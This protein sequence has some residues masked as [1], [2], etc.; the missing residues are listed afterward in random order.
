[1]PSPLP[2][3]LSLCAAALILAGSLALSSSSFAAT[4]STPDPSDPYESD[5]TRTYGI[6]SDFRVVGWDTESQPGQLLLNLEWD[7]AANAGIRGVVF[8]DTNRDG[9]ADYALNIEYS[10]FDGGSRHPNLDGSGGKVRYKLEQVTKSTESCQSF[11]DGYDPDDKPWTHPEVP[12]TLRT[13][14]TKTL[15]TIPIPIGDIGT[16]RSFVWAA[17]SESE[18]GFH[19]PYDFVPDGANGGEDP[20]EGGPADPQKNYGETNVFYCSPSDGEDSSS[21]WRVRM[22]QGVLFTLVA[23]PPPEVTIDQSPASGRPGD[24][25]TFTAQVKDG[26]QI[27]S[28]AWDLDGDDQFDDG[29]TKTVSKHFP[30]GGR[31]FVRVEV[32]DATQQS[33]IGERTVDIIDAKP[34]VTLEQSPA[35]AR[36]KREVQLTAKATDDGTITGYAWDLDNDGEFDDA[37]GATTSRTFDR[38]GTFTVGVRVSDDGGNAPEVKR[39]VVV[40]ERAPTLRLVASNPSPKAREKTTISAEIVDDGPVDEAD[41]TWGFDADNKGDDDDPY[42]KHRG[43]SWTVGF[44]IP[45]RYTVKAQFTDDT[46]KTVRE[47]IVIDVPN[48]PP[49][50]R[51]IRVRVKKTPD[52]PFNRDLLVKDKPLYLE[53]LLFDDSLQR[54]RVDWDI[55]NDGAYDDATGERVEHTFATPGEKTVGV[56]ITDDG[57]HVVL[58]D[59]SFEIRDSAEAACSGKV[60][61]DGMRATGCFTKAKDGTRTTKEPLKINGLDIVPA[62]NTTVRLNPISG[63]VDTGDGDITIKAGSVVLWEGKWKMDADCDRTKTSCLAFKTSVPELAKLKG[64]PLKGEAEVYFTPTGTRVRVNVDIFGSIGFG[65]TTKVDLTVHDVTGLELEDLEI[66]TPLMPL[67]KNLEIGQFWLKYQKA[68]KRWAGGGHIV[69]PTPQFTKLLGDFAFSEVTGFERAHGE[70]DGL[71]VPIDAFGTVYLQRIAFT[72]EIKGS[73]PTTRVRIGGGLG[74][75]FGPRVGG[76]DALTIDGD[77]L[78][79]FGW[80]L[81]I[82]VEGRASI[83]GFDIFGASLGAR[84]NGTVY[85]DGFIGFGLPFPKQ[86]KGVR[87]DGTKLKVSKFDADADIFNPF[88][89]VTVRGEASAW[90][91]PDAFNVEAHVFAKVI[92][93]TL[94]EARGLMS[95]KGIAGCG[96]V[97]GI[98]GGFGYNWQTEKTDV[99]GGSCDLAPWRPE[100]KL[101]PAD[102]E[103]TGR[104]PGRTARAAQS[105]SDATEIEVPAGQKALMLKLDGRGGDPLVTLVSPSGRRYEMPREELSVETADWLAT[106]HPQADETYV[107]VRAPAAGRWRIELQSGSVPLADVHRAAVLPKPQVDATVRGSGRTRTIDYAI[108]P[109]PGQTVEFVEHGSDTRRTIGVAKGARGS[110]RFVPREGKGAKRRLIAIVKQNGLPREHI[111]V[112]R[113]TAPGVRM[114]ARPSGLRAHRM[115]GGRVALAWKP[116]PGA[117]KYQVIALNSDGSSAYRPT[118]STR[119]VIARVARADGMRFQVRAVDRRAVR[120]RAATLRLARHQLRAPRR[121]LARRQSAVRRPRFTG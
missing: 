74:A 49:V 63:Y 98:S 29:T 42:D 100:R 113:F 92:G 50:F 22:A 21:G 30:S 51:E 81:G 46:G 76:F 84:T 79:T 102:G 31:R 38:E 62:R 119:A 43:R 48:T 99:F 105:R 110:L 13:S 80:P 107:G 17:I 104:L 28:Y 6:S 61:V 26:R 23:A 24:T 53:T 90:V 47:R 36:P 44:G 88:Q 89:I 85:A 115:A 19:R 60:E 39:D 112:T 45:H 41:I 52:E 118:G 15:A 116:V 35:L 111:R 37:T 121:A 106:R 67:P 72:L 18:S 33:A 73:G 34:Q 77:F 101:A 4:Q 97:I 16:P 109:I 96:S 14:D 103:G 117:I 82:D 32:V 87:K 91:E 70:I 68:G 27:S 25:L 40:A 5:E 94:A 7:F 93:I 54:P 3:W 2:R 56:K 58:G 8:L 65:L 66:R 71:N 1:M 120:S 64:L 10:D 108:K 69:I 83:A 86:K 11:S 114:P 12:A 95:S 57:G 55:D 20:F 78:F 59:T 75:S 9:K